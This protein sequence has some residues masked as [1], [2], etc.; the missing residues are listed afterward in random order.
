MDRSS[1]KELLKEVAGANVTLKDHPEWV[2]VP[3]L[4]AQWKHDTGKDSHPSAGVSVQESGTSIYNCHACHTKLPLSAMLQQLSDYSGSDYAGLIAQLKNE[5]FLG[6]DLPPWGRSP[7]VVSASL[8]EPLD[9]ETYLDLFD[10]AEDHW[11]VRSRDINS[12]TARQL[13][14]LVDPDDAGEERVLFPVYRAKGALYGFTGRATA[15][16]VYPP[17][18]DYYGLPKR[19]LLLGMHLLPDDAKYVILVEGLFDQARLF[20][21]GFPV[22]A[23]MGGHPTEHHIDMLLELGLPV[24]LFRDN[25][26]AGKLLQEELKKTKLCRHLPVMKV[27]YP[28]RKVQ[29]RN[30]RLRNVNDPDELWAS[31]IEHMIKDA[32]I[33]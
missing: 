24:Y 9:E 30:G 1:I 8:G 2:G 21:Y 10:S 18:R 7:S 4:F 27:R 17:T 19:L 16:G 13:G 32:R 23:H 26:T 22:V 12:A 29:D 25:D 5:I 14:L 15:S 28:R 33:L 3:C 6:G 11:Y 31:E 20:Q